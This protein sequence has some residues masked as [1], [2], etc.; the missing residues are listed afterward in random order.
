MLPLISA[1]LPY[2]IFFIVL[3][4]QRKRFFKELAQDVIK[5]IVCLYYIIPMG[6]MCFLLWPLANYLVSQ[7]LN[8]DVQE[9]THY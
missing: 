6:R 4:A 7:H 2:L 5:T 9:N 1:G 8:T 3:F